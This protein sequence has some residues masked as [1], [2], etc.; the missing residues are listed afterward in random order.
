[1]GDACSINGRYVHNMLVGNANGRDNVRGLYLAGRTSK[2]LF[3][4]QG[5]QTVMR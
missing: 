5:A 3:E 2:W 4:K 1:M